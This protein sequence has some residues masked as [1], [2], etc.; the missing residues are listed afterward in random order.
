MTTINDIK[1]ILINN[2]CLQIILPK[3]EAK[4]RLGS[5]FSVS[6]QCKIVI[7]NCHRKKKQNSHQE[8]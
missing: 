8:Y 4:F 3:D 5:K 1:N 7:K 2:D 6:V